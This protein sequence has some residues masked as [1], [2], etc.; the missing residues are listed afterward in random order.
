MRAQSKDAA[1]GAICQPF[2]TLVYN[3]HLKDGAI[4]PRREPVF[5]DRYDLTRTAAMITVSEKS[6]GLVGALSMAV[7]P[8]RTSGISD[9]VSSPEFAIFPEAVS[10]LSDPDKPVV[11]GSRFCIEP[12]HPLRSQIALLI[13]IAQ[14]CA[15]RTVGARWGLASARG[16]HLA[17][18]KRILHMSE[19]AP[20]RPMPGLT[21]EYALLA[22]DVIQGFRSI[23]AGF[24]ESCRDHFFSTCPNW[25]D[26]VRT[27]FPSISMA[28]A[29]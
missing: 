23:I 16:S 25:S 1:P 12:D 29:A 13:L 7:Q 28:E 9:F 4:T 17:F 27:A 5:I 6:Q 11:T 3:S 18:Y 15:T 14:V 26:I 22:G 8:P 21:R 24:P 2:V 20:P 19:I 10:A